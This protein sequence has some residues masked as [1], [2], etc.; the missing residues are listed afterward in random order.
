MRCL[1]ELAPDEEALVRHVGGPSRRARRIMALGLS[2]G[3]TV[4]VVRRAPLGDPMEL[5]VSGCLLVLRREEASDV[6]LEG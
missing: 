3:A 5:D 6:V 2:P 1:A 4:R